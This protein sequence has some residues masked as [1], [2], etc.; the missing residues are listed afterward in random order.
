VRTLVALALAATVVATPIAHAD[1]PA[2]PDR[3]AFYSYSG[4]KPLADIAPGSVLKM[5]ATTMYFGPMATPIAGEQL[6]YRTTGQLGQPTVTV[7]TVLAPASVPVIPDIVG[8]L[9]FYDGLD[10]KCDPSYTLAGGDAGGAAQ[11]EAE[12]EELL[13]NWYLS[14]GFVVTVP[15]F[16]GTDLDWMAGRESGYGTL[17]AIRATE[18][19]LHA[20]DAEVGLSGYSGGAVAGDWASELAPSYAP[21]LDLVGV[22]IGGVPVNY[23]HLFQYANGNAEYAAAIPAMLLGLSRARHVDLSPYLSPYGAKVV[24][25]ESTGCMPDL[26]GRWPGLTLAKILKPAYRD[27]RHVPAIAHLLRPQTMGTAPGHPSTSTPIYLG[28]GNSD[29]KGDGVMRAG[30][31]QALADEYCRQGVPVR[32]EEYRG[33]SHETAGA[34]FEPKTGPFLQERFA[35]VPFADNCP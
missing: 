22:A 7:T 30:D 19:Y 15:D 4:S 11:Q 17:D 12:E 10:P 1:G 28:V 23:T 20:P 24:R 33:A 29:G 5:R 14:Q 6:L 25:A 9:S 34:F 26:F 2:R 27:W 18:S 31:V 32:F 21:K 16:E 3:D 35:G 8:Y 13:V